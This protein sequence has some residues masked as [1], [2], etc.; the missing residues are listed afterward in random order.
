VN[1]PISLIR[2]TAMA[3]QGR[4]YLESRF[5]PQ[6]HS[7]V[8]TVHLRKAA[9]ATDKRLLRAAAWASGGGDALEMYEL[10]GGTYKGIGG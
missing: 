2:K 5:G 8:A 6:E 3:E 1:A 10:L 4:R 9:S 7:A